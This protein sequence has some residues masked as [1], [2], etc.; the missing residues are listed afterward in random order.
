MKDLHED[1]AAALRRAQASGLADRVV[2]YTGL[3][4]FFDVVHRL[5]SDRRLSR[6][7]YLARKPE[8]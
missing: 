2:R 3:Q 7:A 5:S 8:S 4:S 1:A 6:F